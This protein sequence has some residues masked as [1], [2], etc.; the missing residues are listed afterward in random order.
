MNIDGIIIN[1]NSSPKLI[2]YFCLNTAF[3]ANYLNMISI[4]LATENPYLLKKLIIETHS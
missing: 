1:F 2:V 3:I 4:Y